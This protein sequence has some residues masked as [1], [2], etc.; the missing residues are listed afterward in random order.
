MSEI[1]FETE[2]L[3]VRPWGHEDREP[4]SDLNA[5]PEVMR[6]FPSILDRNESDELINRIC[7]KITQDGFCFLP[8]E[9]KSSGS[10]L[11]FVGLSIPVFSKPV[12]FEPCVEI[13]WRLARSAWGKGYATEAANAWLRFGFD[14]LGIQE[15]VSFTT[16]NN[17][18]SRKVVKRLGMSYE[19]SDDFDH[20][21]LP[22]THCLK[23]HVLYRLSA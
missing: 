13:G 9:E 19:A 14:T 23:R 4:F 2:R 16:I 18:R 15:I 1:S 6:Y 11:G 12:H 5:D 20:P 21:N 10:F 3:L 8:I 22:D 17:W 7:E